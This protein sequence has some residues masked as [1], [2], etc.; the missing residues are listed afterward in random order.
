MT[1]PEENLERTVVIRGTPQNA[2]L[3]EIEIRRIVSEMPAIEQTNIFIPSRAAGRIIGAN[4]N[5]FVFGPCND[6][7][8][9]YN[10]KYIWPLQARVEKQSD[11]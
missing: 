11:I 8:L 5:N 9:M 1:G 10:I 3:A 6:V 7:V 4:F 2:Q